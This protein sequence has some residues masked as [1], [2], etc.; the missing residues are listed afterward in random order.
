MKT[1]SLIVTYK[2][3]R[4]KLLMDEKNVDIHAAVIKEVLRRLLTHSGML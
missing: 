4:P 1:G 3:R 2:R